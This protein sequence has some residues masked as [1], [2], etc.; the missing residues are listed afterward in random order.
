LP[1]SKPAPGQKPGGR[2]GRVAPEK[3]KKIL[4]AGTQGTSWRE[5]ACRHE[6]ALG[7]A[8]LPLQL[9]L[10]VVNKFLSKKGETSIEGWGTE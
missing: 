8:P 3:L 10:N 9:S 6:K 5:V 1:V 4:E 2:E 7:T